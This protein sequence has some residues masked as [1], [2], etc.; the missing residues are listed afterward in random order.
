[1]STDFFYFI[2]KYAAKLP[3]NFSDKQKAEDIGAK[4]HSRKSIKQYPS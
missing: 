3:Q 4:N 2:T 1:M